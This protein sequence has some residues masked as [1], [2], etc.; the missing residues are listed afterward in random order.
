MKK[1]LCM[2]L[3]TA[4]LLSVMPIAV[5]AADA[6]PAGTPITTAE[7]LHSLADN[8]TYYLANDITITPENALYTYDP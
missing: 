4:M 8:G 3:I 7:Q 6:T 5:F 2:L 1:T